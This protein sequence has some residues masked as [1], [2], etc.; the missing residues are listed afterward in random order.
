MP[1]IATA[2]IRA[3]AA[4]AVTVNRTL[5]VPVPEAG[6]ALPI[7]STVLC[8]LHGQPGVDVSENDTSDC[9]EPTST[10]VGARENVHGAAC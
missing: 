10:A 5:A 7:Q 8:A 9:A 3:P 6:V 2:P 1:P 4:L